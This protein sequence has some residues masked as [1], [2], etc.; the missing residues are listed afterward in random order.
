MTNTPGLWTHTILPTTFTLTLDD[1]GIKF[2]A[3]DNATHLLDALQKNYFITLDPSGS[4]Y[5]WL[6]IKWN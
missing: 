6:T 1:F 4:K 2:F 5:C 3:A